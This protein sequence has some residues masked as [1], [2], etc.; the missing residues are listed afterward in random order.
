MAQI[1]TYDTLSAERAY[2]KQTICY[3]RSQKYSEAQN[4]GHFRFRSFLNRCQTTI[5]VLIAPLA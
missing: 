2:F 3:A 5:P 1:T 4:K